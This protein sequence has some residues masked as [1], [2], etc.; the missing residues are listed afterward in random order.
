MLGSYFD[1]DKLP[2]KLEIYGSNI[3]INKNHILEVTNENFSR[4]CRLFMLKYH[5]V[6]KDMKYIYVDVIDKQSIK[7]TDIYNGN[8]VGNLSV[9]CENENESYILID[10]MFGR[11]T[12]LHYFLSY[13]DQKDDKFSLMEDYRISDN[14]KELYKKMFDKLNYTKEEIAWLKGEIRVPEYDEYPMGLLVDRF[15]N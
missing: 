8:W 2:D 15:E 5:I 6:N 3:I 14:L 12:L 10:E 13:I 9:T 4:I 1:I 7:D 11:K